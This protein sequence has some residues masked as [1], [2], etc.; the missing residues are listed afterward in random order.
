MASASRNIVA[1]LNKGEKLNGENYEIWAMKIQYVLEK[2]EVLTVLDHILTE[3]E[4]GTTPKH[5]SDSAAF[6]SWKKKNFIAR[7]TLLSSMENDVMREFRQY[8]VAKEMWLALK[9]KFGGTSVTKLRQLTIK[10]DT[11]KKRPNHN[12][13]QHLR[14]MSNMIS[15][16]NDADHILTDEQQV[17]AV[18]R[19][20]PYTWE[21]MKVNLTHNEGLKLSTMLSDI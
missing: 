6:E 12:M 8:E 10:F 1:E 11:Y 2:Q 7:I 15:E 13:R 3:P 18:I 14:E 16:L 20:L 4:K 9:Q 17:Q 5:I 19:S 21:H